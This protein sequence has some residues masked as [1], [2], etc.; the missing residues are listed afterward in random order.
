MP[1]NEAQKHRYERD[2][3]I[4]ICLVFLV[5]FEV[6]Q[7]AMTDRVPLTLIIMFTVGEWR[8]LALTSL[9]SAACNVSHVFC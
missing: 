2:S 7:G 6:F 1:L 5:V 8:D 9:L 4:L 3:F